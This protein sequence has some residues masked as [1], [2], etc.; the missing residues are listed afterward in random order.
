[1]ADLARLYAAIWAAGQPHGITDFGVQA[2]NALRMEKG[3]RGYGSELTNEI[4]LVEADCTRFYCPDKGNF[5]GRDATEAVRAAGITTTLVYGEIAATDCD[6]YGGEAVMQGD[7]VVGVC[8]SGAYG[9]ATGKSL[10]FAY[11]VPGATDGLDVIILGERRALT[12]L[13]APAWDPANVRQKA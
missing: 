1:M 13:D 6:I 5:R 3:Y 10:A 11:V 4:T 8:T 2:V 12:V 9:H 7:R